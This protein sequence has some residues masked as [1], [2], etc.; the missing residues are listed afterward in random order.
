MK[1]L[2][3]SPIILASALLLYYYFG[4]YQPQKQALL[5]QNEQPEQS[6][7]NAPKQWETKSDDQP[8]VVIEM[9]PVEF[10]QDAKTWRFTIVFDTHSGSLDQDPTKVISLS[11]DNGNTYQPIAWE[12]PGPGGHHREGTLIFNPIQPLPGYVELKIKDVGG[13]A[14]RSFK[15]SSK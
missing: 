7:N 3:F 9:T 2:K 10:G 6:I 15:W 4:V 8:P 5:P 12:G 1:Y 14:E 11:D 13:I